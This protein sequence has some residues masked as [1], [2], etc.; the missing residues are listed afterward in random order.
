[1]ELSIRVRRN[2]LGLF[3]SRLYQ[4]TDEV[5]QRPYTFVQIGGASRPVVHLDIDI[6]MVIYMPWAIY[7]LAHIPCRLA[8]RLPGRELA[9]NK[10]R[11]N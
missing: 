1:M 5:Y 4:G 2:R 9:I 11:P 7:P 10:Y 8:G 6:I 3:F